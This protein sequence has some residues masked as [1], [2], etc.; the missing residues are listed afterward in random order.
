MSDGGAL[1]IWDRLFGTYVRPERRVA[2]GI[3]G[4]PAPQTIVELYTL[5]WR[6][7]LAGGTTAAGDDDSATTSQRDLNGQ[8]TASGRPW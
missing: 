8:T 5:P 7:F 3:G 4:E 2:Y 1:I 6:T